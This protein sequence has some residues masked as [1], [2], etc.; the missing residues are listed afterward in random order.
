MLLSAHFKN[1][2]WVLFLV[3]LSLG[4]FPSCDAKNEN[5]GQVSQ[6]TAQADSAPVTAT[7]TPSSRPLNP[8]ETKVI[9]NASLRFQVKDF[10]QSLHRVQNSL[11]GFG[12]FLASSQDNRQENQLETTLEIRVPATNL[13]PLLEHL[14]KES[15][16]LDYRNLSSEDVTTEFVDLNSR[17]KAKIAVEARFLDLLHQ[18]KTIRDILQVEQELKTI[19]E[20]IEAMQGRLNLIN[21]RVAYSTI[22]LTIYEKTAGLSAGNPFLV[23]MGNALKYGWDLALS[24]FI[25][26]LYIWP[27]LLLLPLFLFGTRKWLRRYPPVR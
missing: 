3:S 12:A 4:S 25:G 23:R 10:N 5:P 2:F 14:V 16:Y 19:R 20:E 24:L 15:I 27:L 21:T 7:A 11:K 17:L 22:T 9:R 8:S 26:L 13:D 6:E 18:A 1:N